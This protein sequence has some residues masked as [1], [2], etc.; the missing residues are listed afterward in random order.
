[1]KTQEGQSDKRE[2]D[3]NPIFYCEP[4]MYRDVDL[5]FDLDEDALPQYRK[6]YE[7]N[8]KKILSE[9][10]Q[11][12]SPGGYPV[13]SGS[14]YL[15]TH[16]MWDLN[17]FGLEYHLPLTTANYFFSWLDHFRNYP[18][19]FYVDRI[20][21]IFHSDWTLNCPF[22]KNDRAVLWRD[23]FSYRELREIEFMPWLESL[24]IGQ[25]GGIL[26]LAEQYE[27]VN[28]AFILSH[29]SRPRYAYSFERYLE[30]AYI[31]FV[32]SAPERKAEQWKINYLRPI[33]ARYRIWHLYMLEVSDLKWEQ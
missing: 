21:D 29:R 14:D 8:L 15:A 23:M 5:L 11:I 30:E 17:R 32:L 9:G 16:L 2:P 10:S 24:T 12:L 1:M 18:R 33:L 25:L 31:E 13:E 6:K 3:S 27:S 19:K 20:L 7:G 28:L 22:E 4:D 26:I